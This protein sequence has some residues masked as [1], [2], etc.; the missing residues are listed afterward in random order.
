M[1]RRLA[2]LALKEVSEHALVLLL[3]LFGLAGGWTVFLLAAIGGPTTLTYLEAHATFVRFA[4]PT[5]GL[6]LGNRLVVAELSGRT[7]RF[8]EALPMRPYEPL[9]V[10]WLLGLALL[11]GVAFAS[12]AAAALVAS[13]R[14]P[15]DAPF[16]ALLGL[17]TSVVVLWGWSFFFSM[18]LF[19]KLRV[20]LYLGLLLALAIVGGSTSLEISRFGPFALAGPDMALERREVPWAAVGE[21]LALTAF[22]LAA[23]AGV[24][25]LREGSVEE[26]LQKPMSQRDLAMAGIAFF[27]ILIVWGELSPTPEPAPYALPPDHVLHATALPI[28]VSYLD[29]DAEDDAR[30]L[31]ARLE[32][33]VGSLAEAAGYARLPQL[34]VV[35]RRSLDAATFE[36]VTLA[37]SDGVLMRANFLRESDPDLD[38]LTAEVIAALCDARTGGRARL[39]PRRWAREGVA[40]EWASTHR[41][42]EA[43]A[44]GLS[45]A[46]IAQALLATRARGPDPARMARFEL[47]R[48]EVGARAAAALSATGIAA[49]RAERGDAAVSAL[50]REAFPAGSTD[51]FRVV[52]RD[53]LRPP[54]E[55]GAGISTEALGAAW[56]AELARLRMRPDAAEIVAALRDARA[57]L[58]VERDVAG[59]PALVVR[60]ETGAPGRVLTVRHVVLGPFDR[61][62]EDV[63]TETESVVADALGHAEVRLEGRYAT[64]DRV[65][66]R[67]DLEGTP[68]GAPHRLLSRRL[69][70][71]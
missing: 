44:A 2:A 36:P 33:S 49:I 3:V 50:V 58:T 19:G 29:D 56:S 27:S 54:P 37:E 26:R 21:C 70:V 16:L 25:S 14:E 47:L 5:L 46:R 18:G 34:R 24:T 66:V 38:G 71:P 69:E 57:S 40:L 9:L 65:L 39:E 17:R 11:L 12:L 60:A 63:T 4:L 45:A 55:A 28:A 41:G 52:L 48:E 6:A 32:A 13:A 22:F 20:P 51:D 23:G 67:V 59:L 42:P 64:G 30:V 62:V 15:I 1:T 10:K 53:W 43:V 61:V 8:L 31:L 7:Q 68:L 35:L